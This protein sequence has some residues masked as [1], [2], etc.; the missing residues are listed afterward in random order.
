MEPRCKL[1]LERD[2]VLALSDYRLRLLLLI[3]ETG[4]LAAAAERMNLSY[5]RAWGKIREIED[6]LG[7]R[8]V[9]SESGGSS[10]GRSRLTPQGRDMVRRY[11]RFADAAHDAVAAA[12]ENAFN[13]EPAPGTPATPR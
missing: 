6:H 3:E 11:Q 2:G 1:W 12:Y 13:P 10:G 9:E 7:F 4:S 5:R 8:L